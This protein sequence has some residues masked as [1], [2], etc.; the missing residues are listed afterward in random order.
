VAHLVVKAQELF[1]EAVY[2]LCLEYRRTLKLVN[3]D[4]YHYSLC[5]RVR[6]QVLDLSQRQALLTQRL[7]G[8]EKSQFDHV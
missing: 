5:V 7:E 8:A 3:D 1:L 6:P 2:R 4:Q